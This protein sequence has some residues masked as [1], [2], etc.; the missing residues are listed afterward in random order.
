[1]G[2]KRSWCLLDLVAYR[3][4][5]ISTSLR[6]QL[7]HGAVATATVAV[8]RCLLRQLCKQDWLYDVSMG[9]RPSSKIHSSNRANI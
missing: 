6:S 8:D 2:R 1:M 5:A 3:D 7:G 9:L 4:I